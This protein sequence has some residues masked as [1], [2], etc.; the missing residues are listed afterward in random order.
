MERTA[1]SGRPCRASGSLREACRALARLPRLAIIAFVAVAAPLAAS[2]SAGA[3]GAETLVRVSS[4]T[5]AQIG[6]FSERDYQGDAGRGLRY[7]FG[8][9]AHATRSRYGCRLRW[10]GIGLW[11]ELTTYGQPLD[12]CRHGYFVRARLSGTSWHTPSGLRIGSA[13]S[14]ARRQAV[15]GPGRLKCFRGGTPPGYVLGVHRSDCALGLFPNVIATV[16]SGRVRAFWVYT[17][18]CE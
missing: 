6:A 9:P 7:A 18:T 12:S 5:P 17:H 14:R 4:A 13:A 1:E 3:Q 11:A 8:A 10:P 2:D 15:C 16:G